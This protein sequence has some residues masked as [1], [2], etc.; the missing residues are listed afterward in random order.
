MMQQPQ[1]QLHTSLQRF[2][3]GLA[4]TADEIEE[5]QRL[6]YKVFAEEMGARLPSAHEHIDRDIF[7]P[8]CDHLLVRDGHSAKVVG[9]YRI[10][11]PAQAKAVGGY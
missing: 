1:S 10:L 9:T 7:D 2:S 11:P 3:V 8:Y 5:A 4:R 6:R